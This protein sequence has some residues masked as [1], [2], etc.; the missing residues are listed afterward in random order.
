[1]KPNDPEEE[2]FARQEVERRRREQAAREAQMADEEKT[3]LRELHWMKCPKCG[4]DMEEYEYQGV[5][6]DRCRS[7]GGV[8]FDA[9]E[10]EQLMEH[11]GD[12]VERFKRLFG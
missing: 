4:M 11:K 6:L 2:Y 12:F 8:F 10:M 7:C 5:S 9:G 3:R 1:M